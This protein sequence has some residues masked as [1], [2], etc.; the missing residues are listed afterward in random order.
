MKSKKVEKDRNTGGSEERRTYY[1]LPRDSYGQPT[2]DIVE[3]HLTPEE[4]AK[5]PFVY[6]S[7]MAA[8][9]RAMD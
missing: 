2:G 6:E 7:Y 8:V 5:I 1:Y 4:A 9:A 3:R